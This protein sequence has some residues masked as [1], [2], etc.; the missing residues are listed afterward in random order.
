MSETATVM[1]KAYDHHA[2]EEELYAWW[3]ARGYFRPETQAELGQI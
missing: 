3:E 1:P 2:V